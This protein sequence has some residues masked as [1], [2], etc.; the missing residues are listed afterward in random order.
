MKA[1]SKWLLLL[2]V[3]LCAGFLAACSDDDDELIESVSELTVTG[4]S[5]TTGMAG[6]SVTISGTG[7]DSSSTV[8]FNGTQSS[9]VSVASS[10]T[11]LV[12]TVPTGATSGTICVRGITDYAYSDDEFTVIANAVIT[13]YSPSSALPGETIQII[14]TDFHEVGADY[15]TVTFSGDVSTQPTSASTTSLT[16]TVPQGAESGVVTVAFG[17]EETVVG[18]EFEVL[19]PAIV[20]Y[21]PTAASVGETVAIT[22]SNFPSSA[23]A[24]TIGV[25]FESADSNVQAT[26]SSYASNVVTVTVPD[27]AL[28]GAITITLS[29]FDDI[30]GDSFTVIPVADEIDSDEALKVTE[31]LVITGTGFP[32]SGEASVYFTSESGTAVATGTFG[33]DGLTVTIPEDAITGEVYFIYEGYTIECGT[34]TI[35]AT[36]Y[37]LFLCSDVAYDSSTG[38]YAIT[39]SLNPCEYDDE[40]GSG[41]CIGEWKN[42]YRGESSSEANSLVIWDQAVGDYIVF[43]A[44]ITTSGDFTVYFDGRVISSST[45]A[46]NV[47]I[48]LSQDLSEVNGTDAASNEQSVAVYGTGSTSYAVGKSPYSSYSSGTFSLTKGTWYIRVHLAEG[49]GSS[50]PILRNVAIANY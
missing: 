16:V 21:S 33:Y 29:G 30:V 25:Y 46:V 7:F 13:G 43:M 17:D 6:T 44:D 19:T 42:G 2:S 47:N 4:F 24:S 35:S 26:V 11:I 36:Y 37:K 34:L 8:F 1:T 10:G 50:A 9:S 45:D 28:T 22:V 32:V 18:P 5:P 15:I 31:T 27:G 3:T 23:T 38:D 39:S 20:S 40:S 14:G 48:A 12:A 41:N 49:L